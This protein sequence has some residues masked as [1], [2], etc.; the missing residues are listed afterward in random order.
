MPYAFAQFTVSNPRGVIEILTNLPQE[1]EH[2]DL[3]LKKAW[4]RSFMGRYLRLEKCGSN[5]MN[6]PNYLIPTGC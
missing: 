1:R 2:A 6:L 5:C 3:A 4:G